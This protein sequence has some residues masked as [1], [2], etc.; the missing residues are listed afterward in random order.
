[1]FLKVVPLTGDVGSNFF[2]VG[3]PN[4]GNLS[5]RRVGFLGSHRFDL[6]TNTTLLRTALENGGFGLG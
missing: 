4:T 6:Q 2:P 1:V 5:E 3:K